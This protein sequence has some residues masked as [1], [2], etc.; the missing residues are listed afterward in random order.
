MDAVLEQGRALYA[1]EI[2]GQYDK[3]EMKDEVLDG[4]W[5]SIYDILKLAY[6]GII[7]PLEKED[8]E[9]AYRY[10]QET[11]PLTAHH[12]HHHFEF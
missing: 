6:F 7:D 1:Y 8:Y 5:C 11:M 2:S 10:L 12:Q 9:E 3:E 4:V